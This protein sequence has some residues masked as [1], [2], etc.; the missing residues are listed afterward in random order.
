MIAKSH[1]QIPQIVDLAGEFYQES[2]RALPFDPVVFSSTVADFIAAEDRCLIVHEVDGEIRGFLLGICSQY[3]AAALIQ[4][5]ELLWYAPKR[6]RGTGAIRMFSE[7]KLWA[8]VD[9]GARII[10]AGAFEGMAAKYY[11]RAGFS[12]IDENWAMVI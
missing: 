2:G 7:F 4:A 5:H 9:R 1:D 6:H 12:K 3:P 11:Q 10:F 8:V